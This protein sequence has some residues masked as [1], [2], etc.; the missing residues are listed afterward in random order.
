MNY[1]RKFRGGFDE[2]LADSVDKKTS[3]YRFEVEAC[4]DVLA[5][6]TPDWAGDRERAD[7]PVI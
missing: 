7:A 5:E 3:G 6:R 2:D 1:N 4:R